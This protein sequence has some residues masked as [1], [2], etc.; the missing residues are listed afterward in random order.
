M[1]VKPLGIKGYR[2]RGIGGGS[3]FRAAGAPLF[4]RAR[5]KVCGGLPFLSPGTQLI[6]PGPVDRP[7]AA[8]ATVT[9]GCDPSYP[10]RVIPSGPAHARPWPTDGRGK[11][12][13]V[14]IGEVRRDHQQ[15]NGVSCLVQPVAVDDVDPA[16]GAALG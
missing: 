14:A 13:A 9:D 7:A 11:V 4:R 6:A 8:L 1:A 12:V 15:C 16:V 10:G 5:A 2:F 3:S